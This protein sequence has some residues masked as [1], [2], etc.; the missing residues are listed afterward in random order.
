MT[1]DDLVT[2]I[3]DLTARAEQAATREHPNKPYARS[4]LHNVQTY[5]TMLAKLT[6]TA[7]T[8]ESP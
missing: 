4:L 8:V 5:T 6:G 7:T 1:A 3:D 2:A